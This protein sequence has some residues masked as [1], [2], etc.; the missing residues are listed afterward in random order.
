MELTTD[1]EE[2]ARSL[3]EKSIILLAHDHFPPPQDLES[4]RQGGITAKILMAVADA[5]VYAA[6]P[7]EYRQ[8]IP[9][10]DGWLYY[11]SGIYEQV[12]TTIEGSDLLMLVRR[13]ED[14]LEAKRQGKIG[15]LLGA[16]GG[17][18][19]EHR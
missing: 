9:Q 15:I 6:D 12:L 8:S 1:Q 11:A 5:R 18:L 10:I 16:E 19:I 3:H 7:E 4:L 17:K 13:A 14:V 2:R